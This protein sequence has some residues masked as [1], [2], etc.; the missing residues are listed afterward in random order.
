M[1]MLNRKL[2]SRRGL[3][4]TALGGLF[5]APFL[6]ARRLEAQTANPKRLIL[7]FTPDSH[8]PEWWP[9]AG[10][11]PTS[12]TLNEPLSGFEGLEQYLLFPRRVDHSW[13]FDN[14]H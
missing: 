14:H 12:F 1:I 13:S 6:R 9:T 8:P 4:Q 7:A 5:L 3:L 10:A 2:M 11:D